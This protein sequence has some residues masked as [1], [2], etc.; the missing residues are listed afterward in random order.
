MSIN[1]A[2]DK[3]MFQWGCAAT[4]TQFSPL[5]LQFSFSAFSKRNRKWHISA[6]NHWFV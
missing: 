5:S 3:V 6:W 4:A 2:A 1:N